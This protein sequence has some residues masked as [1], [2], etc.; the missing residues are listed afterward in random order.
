MTNH[1]GNSRWFLI[2]VVMKLIKSGVI[3][4]SWGLVV[5]SEAC[6]DASTL[7][8][9]TSLPCG[10]DISSGEFL[11]NQPVQFNFTVIV[12]RW[13]HRVSRLLNCGFSIYFFKHLNLSSR[14]RDMLFLPHGTVITCY[15]NRPPLIA[16]ERD[17]LALSLI[18]MLILVACHRISLLSFQELLFCLKLGSFDTDVTQTLNA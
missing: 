9:L 11:K 15:A 17:V 3:F 16:S 4:L 2:W 1:C 18:L 14:T 6:V 13:C 5:I 12:R 7:Y 10:I 8:A